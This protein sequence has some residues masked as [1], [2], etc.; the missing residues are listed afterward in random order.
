MIWKESPTSRAS[1]SDT[2]FFKLQ[3]SSAFFFPLG[4]IPFQ[5]LINTCS[6]DQLEPQLMS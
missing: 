1:G 5:A 6:T 3:V 2:F 4:D